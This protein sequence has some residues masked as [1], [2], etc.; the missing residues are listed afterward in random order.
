MAEALFNHW[1]Q[2]RLRAY[3]AGSFPAGQVNPLALKTLELHKVSAVGARS[4]S[5]DEFAGPDAPSM[6][7]VITVCDNAANEV[8]PVWPGAPV[9]AH[10]G[11]PDPAAVQGDEAAK[12][13]A[14][15]DVFLM[16]DAR[17]KILVNLRDEHFEHMRLAEEL[18]RIHREA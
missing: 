13:K 12:L 17:I 6:S 14:F 7:I 10:W 5:W 1:G 9:T 2:P 18:R 3:S 11:V 8:C 16:L 4:K 15:K